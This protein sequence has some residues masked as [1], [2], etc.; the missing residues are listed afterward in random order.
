MSISMSP[1]ERS[2][3][4][5]IAAHTLHSKVDSRQHT[6]PARR[7]FLS[8]FE[9]QVDPDGT[10][11]EAERLRRAEHAKQAYFTALSYK[12]ARARSQRRNA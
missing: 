2:M 4:A 6:E 7:A 11:P 10:L 12:A 3:R 5:R 9:K 1:T 8:R